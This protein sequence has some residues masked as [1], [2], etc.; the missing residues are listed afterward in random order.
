MKIIIFGATGG[1]GQQLVEQSLSIGYE[2][3]VFVHNNPQK[4]DQ[5]AGKIKIYQGDVRDFDGVN[6][7]IQGHDAVMIALGAIPGKVQQTLSLGTANIVRVME[8]N[9]IKR[10][11]TE[12]GAALVED[13]N[14]LPMIWRLTPNMP[15][16]R[17]MFDDKRKQ[18]KAIMDSKLDWIIVRPANL[19]NNPLN[20]NYKVGEHIKLQVASSVARADVADFM[21][22]QLTSDTWLKK[23][24]IIESA[25]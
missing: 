12:T 16:M 20:L 4:L 13:K 17:E 22:K 7:A 25:N 21:I 15:L 23:A 8:T 11:V 2:T 6:Q 14:Q 18:E 5:Y 10:L 1:T 19:N 9:N 24:I 3:S